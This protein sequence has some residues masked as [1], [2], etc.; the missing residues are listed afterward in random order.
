MA[1]YVSGYA[2]FSRDVLIVFL[3]IRYHRRLDVETLIHRYIIP[4][5]L[6]GIYERMVAFT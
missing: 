2:L 4:A 6:K 3:T 5:C 1:K